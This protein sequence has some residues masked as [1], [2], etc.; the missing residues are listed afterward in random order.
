MLDEGI[1]KLHNWAKHDQPI[2]AMYSTE[3]GGW[4][5]DPGKPKERSQPSG[6]KCGNAMMSTPGNIASTSSSKPE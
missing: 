4:I 3:G 6:R 2:G 5:N 1:S